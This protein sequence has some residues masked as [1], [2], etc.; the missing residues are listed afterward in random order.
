MW[1]W[2]FPQTFVGYLMYLSMRK[3]PRE[4]Y[5]GAL[6]TT[7]AHGW[8]G[9]SF[10]MFTF[11]CTRGTPETRS[12]MRAHEFGHCVQSLMLGPLY[13]P[14]ISLPSAVW[15][16]SKRCKEYR[17]KNHISYYDFWTERWANSLAERFTG[18]RVM[19]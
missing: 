18:D 12:M 13:L 4:K 1:T 15:C 5:H 6:V 7:H 10:G 11:I 8:G 16:N 17:K 9:V 19:K 3:C 2:C 14:L